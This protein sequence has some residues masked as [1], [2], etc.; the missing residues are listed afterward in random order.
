MKGECELDLQII[1]VYWRLSVFNSVQLKLERSRQHS[2]K[3]SIARFDLTENIRLP[4]FE[5]FPSRRLK[6]GKL[7]V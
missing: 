7:N 5:V 1:R 6:L 4:N 2:H 3:N